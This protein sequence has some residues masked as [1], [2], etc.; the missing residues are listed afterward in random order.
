MNILNTK[1]N[2]VK[3]STKTNEAILVGYLSTSRVYRVYS[4]K[5]FIVDESSNVVFDELQACT[6]MTHPMK[7]LSVELKKLSLEGKA[8]E[9]V[10]DNLEDHIE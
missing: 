8:Y 4:K 6:Q 9:E 10:R 5:S 3:F 7:V 2:L 1:H